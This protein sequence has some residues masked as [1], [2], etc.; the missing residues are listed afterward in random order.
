MPRI[1][2]FGGTGYLA[3]LIRNQNKISKKCLHFFSSNKN[4]KNYINFDNY[5]KI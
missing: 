4:N 3:S 2:I 1:A 5:K